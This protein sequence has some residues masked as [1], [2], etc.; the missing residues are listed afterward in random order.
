MK[1]LFGLSLA[2]IL[3]VF[4]AFGS[5]LAASAKVTAK[6][7][8]LEGVVEA[9]NGW[10]TVFTTNIHTPQDKELFIDVSMECGLTTNTKVMS[11][12]LVRAISEAEAMV[13][14]RVLV[15]P[16]FDDGTLQ[17]SAAIASPGEII[18]AKRY[19]ALIAEFAGDISGALSI[20]DGVLVINE[21]LIE[22]EMLALIL[23]TMSANSF[24]FIAQNLDQGFHDIVVQAK[25]SY[26]QTGDKFVDSLGELTEEDIA[27]M[28]Y[29]GNGSVTVE[30]VRMTQDD[31]VLQ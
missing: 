14:V 9:N 23:K 25:L 19:Q 21:D 20:E 3:T 17:N 1:K 5:A 22:P 11:K 10:I 26:E 18:F 12:Q 31:N 6:C 4:L 7:G 8:D 27:T 29:L 24:N 30:C 15:D 2:V 13:E 16:V 28:A